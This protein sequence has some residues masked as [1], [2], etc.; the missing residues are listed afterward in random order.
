VIPTILLKCDGSVQE[1]HIDCETSKSKSNFARLHTKF[2]CVVSM[3]SLTEGVEGG[4]TMRTGVLG[5][6]LKPTLSFKL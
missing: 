1:V 4:L 3:K 6:P 5:R 2:L